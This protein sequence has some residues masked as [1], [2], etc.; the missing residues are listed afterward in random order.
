MNWE[1]KSVVMVEVIY[2]EIKI[3]H[4]IKDV[5]YFLNDKGSG[6][7]I[8]GMYFGIKKKHILNDN[9]RELMNVVT[10]HGNLTKTK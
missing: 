8:E 7:M 6:A 10:H 5:I 3:K 4:I 1:V 9:W 2:F